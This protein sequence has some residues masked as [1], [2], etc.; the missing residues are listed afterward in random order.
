MTGDRGSAEEGSE[1]GGVVECVEGVGVAE[2]WGEDEVV[3]VSIER[4]SVEALSEDG[5]VDER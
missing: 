2:S 3:V 5:G 1:C 4:V